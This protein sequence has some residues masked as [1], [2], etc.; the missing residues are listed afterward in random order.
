[1]SE[2]A[3][4]ERFSAEALDSLCERAARMATEAVRAARLIIQ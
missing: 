3:Q 2:D 1:M 4:C